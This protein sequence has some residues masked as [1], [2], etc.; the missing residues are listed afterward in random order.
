[1][2]IERGSSSMDDVSLYMK[3]KRRDS[4]RNLVNASNA[5]RQGDWVACE[6]HSKALLDGLEFHFGIEESIL[7]PAFEEETGGA[8]GL[9]RLM[10]LE[11]LRLRKLTEKL[12]EALATKDRGGYLKCANAFAA[13]MRQHNS[14]EEQYFYPM[15]EDLLVEQCPVLMAEIA[16]LTDDA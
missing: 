12:S 13:A 8:I 14:Q 16:D 2:S 4:D 7:F 15:I 3:H 11:H 10:L 5:A 1:M 9:T 6:T